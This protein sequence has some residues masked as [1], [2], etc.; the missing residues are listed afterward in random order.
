MLSLSKT[1]QLRTHWRPAKIGEVPHYPGY[2]VKFSDAA[3]GVGIPSA[4]NVF[5]RLA[6]PATNPVYGLIASSGL[7]LGLWY[8]TGKYETG[9]AGIAQSLL[10]YWLQGLAPKA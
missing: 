4:V 2:E 9:M 6:F 1:K 7:S 8:V 10:L 3:L 5:Q